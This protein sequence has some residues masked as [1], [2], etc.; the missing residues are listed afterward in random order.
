MS[1][2]DKT[3][4]PLPTQPGDGPVPDPD[5]TTVRD[6]NSEHETPLGSTEPSVQSGA[7]VQ[8][9]LGHARFDAAERPGAIGRVG[10][11]DSTAPERERTT[12]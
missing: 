9:A 3:T 10:H 6:L 1:A 11:Y 8:A 4:L 7:V 5:G 2:S 12:V